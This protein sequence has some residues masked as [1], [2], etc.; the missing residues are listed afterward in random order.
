MS[1]HL[2][3]FELWFY[4]SQFLDIKSLFKLGLIDSKFN[5]LTKNPNLWHFL[6]GPNGSYENMVMAKNI[7]H[8]IKKDPQVLTM[9]YISQL[10]IDKN[11][12][13]VFILNNNY[14]LH[15]TLDNHYHDL[16]GLTVYI[17]EYTKNILQKICVKISDGQLQIYKRIKYYSITKCLNHIVLLKN[18]YCRI[19]NDLHIK[20]LNPQCDHTNKKIKIKKQRENL[21]TWLNIDEN[22]D[23]I[24][25]GYLHK[26]FE[27]NQICDNFYKTLKNNICEYCK[28]IKNVGYV[29]SLCKTDDETIVI[30][31]P[32][33]LILYDINGNLLLAQIFP[34]LIKYKISK[35]KNYIL[36]IRENEMILYSLEQKKSLEI[37]VTNYAQD[38][39]IITEYDF[40]YPF[41]TIKYKTYIGL[42]YFT[43]KPTYTCLYTFNKVPKSPNVWDYMEYNGYKIKIYKNLL[44]FINKRNL[45]MYDLC[46]ARLVYDQDIAHSKIYAFDINDD[47]LVLKCKKEILWFGL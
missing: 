36:M 24:K 39:D 29:A 21:R 1:I 13:F 18:H 2:L 26:N 44:I 8:K 16:E 5:I 22:Y 41:V 4:I 31:K 12:E 17:G 46:N 23:L 42:F 11:D 30:K 45:T 37:K 35:S 33:E 43:D 32:N 15:N 14:I 20:P 3:P 9:D 28:T 34:D 19:N 27:I 47:L 10:R 7:I 6:Y 38:C 40:E 25:I